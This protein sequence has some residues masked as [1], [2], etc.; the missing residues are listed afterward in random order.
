L[1]G[2]RSIPKTVQLL[3]NDLVSGLEGDRIALDNMGFSLA[4]FREIMNP[5]EEQL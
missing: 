4:K 3:I 1:Y 5:G 2:S